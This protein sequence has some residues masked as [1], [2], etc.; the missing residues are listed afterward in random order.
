MDLIGQMKQVC[1]LLI[2]SQTIGLGA[3]DNYLLAATTRGYL[4]KGGGSRSVNGGDIGINDNW[5]LIV[6]QEAAITTNLRVD[7]KW[8]VGSR[9]FTVQSWEDVE[10]SG[11]Y[12]KFTLT[13]E[14]A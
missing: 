10:E 2:N 7:N 5:T 11:F 1:D 9:L 12:Y 6:R 8:R 4:K 13:E 14:R 3:K